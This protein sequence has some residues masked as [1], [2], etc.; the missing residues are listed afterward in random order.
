MRICILENSVA[1]RFANREAGR[2]PVHSLL[3]AQPSGPGDVVGK[4][5]G[6][7]VGAP[8]DAAQSGSKSLRS[9]ET[10]ACVY[11][12][13]AKPPAPQLQTQDFQR[14]GSRFRLL[15]P[16]ISQLLSNRISK[17][18]NPVPETQL[19]IRAAA[20]R[21]LASTDPA[22]LAKLY[23]EGGR[24]RLANV[25]K[26][27]ALSAEEAK[28]LNALLGLRV[29]QKIDGGLRN[30]MSQFEATHCTNFDKTDLDY[31]TYD[32]MPATPP[33]L[34]PD[35]VRISGEINSNNSAALKILAGTFF[36]GQTFVD[37]V[38]QNVGIYHTAIGG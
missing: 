5:M 1:D 3:K 15:L 27:G 22:D 29:K 7:V 4:T 32:G 21:V 18:F 13:Q 36:T 12:G 16:N 33:Q 37:A 19:P 30:T 11:A 25:Q 35:L 28:V 6:K 23:S 10:N 24:D 14:L 26:V 31:K 34:N 8:D 38:R 2:L 20:S 9:C 17:L